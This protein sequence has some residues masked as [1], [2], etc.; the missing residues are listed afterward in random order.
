M[1]VLYAVVSILV[2]APL[3]VLTLLAIERL[4]R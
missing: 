2:G 4:E 3:G 1:L